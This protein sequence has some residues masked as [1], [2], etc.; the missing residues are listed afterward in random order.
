MRKIEKLDLK[1]ESSCKRFLNRIFLDFV[2]NFVLFD[3]NGFEE[4]V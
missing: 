1:S 4:K 3:F 2:E